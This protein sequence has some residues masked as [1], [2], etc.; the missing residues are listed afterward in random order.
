MGLIV[1]IVASQF[2]SD[3]SNGPWSVK[4]WCADTIGTQQSAQQAVARG[5]VHSVARNPD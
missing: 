2:A 5:S 1:G 3:V 4:V